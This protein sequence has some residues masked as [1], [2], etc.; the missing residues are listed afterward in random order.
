MSLTHIQTY[1]TA[2]G[3]IAF[4]I[5]TVCSGLPCCSS[6][7]YPSISEAICCD[8]A[9]T[10][11]SS[12]TSVTSFSTL[13][14]STTYLQQFIATVIPQLCNPLI[15][16]PPSSCTVATT[17]ITTTTTTTTT[18]VPP[19]AVVPV[20]SGLSALAVAAA[21]MAVPNVPTLVT[22]QGVPPSSPQPGTPFGGGLP[23]PTSVAAISAL[24][25]VPLGLVPVAIFPPYARQVQLKL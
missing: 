25:L 14:G 3:T 4:D 22:T 17:T 15:P 9:P 24:S 20:I 1:C 19:Y 7:D 10:C 11:I 8:L 18:L 6:F 21:F 5:T 23:L 13:S 12:I 2:P 16:F